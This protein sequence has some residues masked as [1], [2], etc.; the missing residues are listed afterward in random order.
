MKSHSTSTHVLPL[1]TDFRF[2]DSPVGKAHAH[3]H[4][5]PMPAQPPRQSGVSHAIQRGFGR[6]LNVVARPLGLRAN[7]QYRT[8]LKDTSRAVGAFLGDLIYT[9]APDPKALARRLTR[10]HDTAEPVTCR[11]VLF[12]NLLTQR[13]Q[14]HLPQLTDKELKDLRTEIKVL[15]GTKEND[16]VTQ[17]LTAI[18]TALCRESERR[19][20]AAGQVDLLPR[21]QQAIQEASHNPA[22]AADTFSTLTGLTKALMAQCGM[23]HDV[24]YKDE[25]LLAQA[26]LRKVLNDMLMNQRV[27]PSELKAV[28][29]VLPSADLATLQPCDNEHL[30]VQDTDALGMLVADIARQR[31]NALMERF[32]A[33]V[34][35]T[36][37]TLPQ[38]AGPATATALRHL[39]DAATQWKALQKHAAALDLPANKQADDRLQELLE[40][41]DHMEID[42][43]NLRPLEDAE[44]P[45][46]NEALD[47]L[48][49]RNG[50]AAIGEAIA[51]RLA[52]GAQ[53]LGLALQNAMDPLT[54]A[55]MAP[56]AKG[57]KSNEA[58]PALQA[59]VALEQVLGREKAR[60]DALKALH[61]SGGDDMRNF[62]YDTYVPLFAAMDAE[63]LKVCLDA[64]GSTFTHQL[65]ETLKGMGQELWVAGGGVEDDP[66]CV[67]GTQLLG[68]GQALL[69]LL[70]A[71]KTSAALREN[72][73]NPQEHEAP[74]I[75]PSRRH[76][77]IR[78]AVRE[79]FQIPLRQASEATHT[80]FLAQLQVIQ[81]DPLEG[82]HYTFGQRDIH[83]GVPEP[84]WKDIGRAT[85]TFEN[86]SGQVTLQMDPLQ[87]PQGDEAR[88]QARERVVDH[89]YALAGHEPVKAN[90][91][92]KCLNQRG[93]PAAFLFTTFSP[94]SPIRLPDGRAGSPVNHRSESGEEF[95]RT[96]YTVRPGT[97]PG[98]LL[99]HVEYSMDKV[100][101][102]IDASSGEE[103]E[104]DP[105]QSY[106]RFS[107]DIVIGADGSIRSPQPFRFDYGLVEKA[108]V[109]P[110]EQAAN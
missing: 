50:K 76:P 80:E 30:P 4:G 74:D 55:A 21:L 92:A 73:D 46:L 39:I 108:A 26:V 3:R 95:A 110:G 19:V 63:Q 68:I 61:Q 12:T 6:F 36:L 11:G 47:V 48:T 33:A 15:R 35:G 90:V 85:H 20:F 69:G 72:P 101:R 86:A 62:E 45:A 67:T 103:I 14:I 100:S 60:S 51:S 94:N 8:A 37:E 64:L 10:L 81:N 84:T 66:R 5:R 57:A 34:T 79:A 83:T 102:L 99:V 18:H 89:L 25:T 91:V 75:D 9:G 1:P 32:D 98:E 7:P 105:E 78:E 17:D 49:L 82:H 41:L 28:L 43:S 58:G 16:G 24:K 93:V 22:L 29:S 106:A 96:T 56:L 107:T 71:A 59:L 97:Q 53:D 31:A 38:E 70:D 2:P 52:K 77:D 104:L 54:L 27:S 23:S 40:R 109:P 44:L 87:F 88:I 13:L 65:I 42:A